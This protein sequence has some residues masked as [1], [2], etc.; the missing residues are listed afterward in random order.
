MLTL[1]E[2]ETAFRSAEADLEGHLERVA[3]KYQAMI[4]DSP[5]W[6]GPGPDP[7][8][9]QARTRAVSDTERAKTA[10]LRQAAMEASLLLTRARVASRLQGGRADQ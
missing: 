7:E 1:D 8:A 6:P 10:R 4:P 9:E 2:L 5:E 3:A